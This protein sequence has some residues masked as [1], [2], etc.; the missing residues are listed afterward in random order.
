MTQRYAHLSQAHRLDAVQR[1][2]VKPSDT[3]TDTEVEAEA[4]AEL[5]TPQPYRMPKKKSAPGWTRTN[6]PRLSVLNDEIAHAPPE[7]PGRSCDLS[8]EDPKAKF[9]NPEAPTPH[10]AGIPLVQHSSAKGLHQRETDF[11]VR[12]TA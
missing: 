9:S 2:N 10:P 11:P 6:D 3:N 12:A 4:V 8:R 7:F 1:L 5:G